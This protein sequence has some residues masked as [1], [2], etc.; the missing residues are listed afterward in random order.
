MFFSVLKDHYKIGKP[1]GLGFPAMAKP[2]VRPR[3]NLQINTFS[4]TV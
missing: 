3:G 2:A 1:I 4:I